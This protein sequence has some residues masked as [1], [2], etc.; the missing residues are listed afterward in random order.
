MGTTSGGEAA[1]K[2]AVHHAEGRVEKVGPNAV[3]IS[4][5]PVA[6][7]GWGPMT[8]DFSVPKGR[9]PADVK[10]GDA[11]AFD[12]VQTPAGAFEVTRIERRGGKP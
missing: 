11:I 6:S 12:F 2:L 10:S 5:G 7:I 1:P 8:M 9:L 4:H 3:T